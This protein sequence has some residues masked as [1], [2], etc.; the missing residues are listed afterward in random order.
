MLL[1]SRAIGSKMGIIRLTL[2]S[3]IGVG[4][5][6]MWFGRDEGLPENRLGRETVATPIVAPTPPLPTTPTVIPTVVTPPIVVEIP[7]P[8]P[9]PVAAPEPVP[10]PEPII[11][12]EVVPTPEPAPI[13][14]ATP[15]PEPEP[16]PEPTPQPEP[17]VEAETETEPAVNLLPVL[18]VTGSKV[19]MRGGP[20]T[21]DAIVGSLTRGTAVDFLGEVADGW[22]QIIVIN[23]GATGFMSSQFLSPDQ[24]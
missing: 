10:I 15:T 6:M 20:S 22:S 21:G 18:Y 5:A 16:I 13:V 8:Q 19:N 17:I 4:G 9:T 12:P 7:T 3:V 14:E 1:E 2:I 11:M 24:P 23:T